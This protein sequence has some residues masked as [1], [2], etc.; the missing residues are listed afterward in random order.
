MK[1][2]LPSVRE[3]IKEFSRYLEIKYFIQRRSH[4]W[5]RASFVLSIN[6]KNY[7][8]YVIIKEYECTDIPILYT[9]RRNAKYGIL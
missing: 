7:V 4:I 9:I 5:L 8:K 3:Q 2:S 1:C 6:L